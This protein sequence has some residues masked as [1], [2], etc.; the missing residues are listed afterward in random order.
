[1]NDQ[2]SKA[3][4]YID[5]TNQSAGHL[6]TGLPSGGVRLVFLTLIAI[7]FC[8][9][10]A[11]NADAALILNRPNYL[12][13][14]NGLVGYWSFNQ[15]DMA[16]S[17]NDTYA[18]D[19]SGNGNRGQLVNMSTSSARVAGKLG[20]A[21]S[22]DGVNDY[23][24]IA[25]TN[26]SLRF[27]GNATV[28][29]WVKLNS[30]PNEQTAIFRNQAD[31][32]FSEWGISFDVVSYGSPAEPVLYVVHTEGGAHQHNSGDTT[33]KIALGRWYHLVGVWDSPNLLV[34]MN[35]VLET[36]ANVGIGTL[37][38]G[39]NAASKIGTRTPGD[40]V[41]DGL[42]DDVRVYSRALSAD[43]IKRLY[44]IGG[45]L[46]VNTQINNDF[47]KNGLVGWWTFDGKDMA[48]GGASVTAYDRSGNNNTGTLT[49]GPTRVIG[50]LGQAL[51]FD[52][53]DDFVDVDT[54]SNDSLDI[55]SAQS[56]TL[57][58][59][60]KTQSAVS[61]PV[62][63]QRLDGTP[64][65]RLYL[66]ASGKASFALRGAVGGETEISSLGRKDDGTWHHVVGI[67]DTA[68]DVMKL[69][70]DGILEANSPDGTVGDLATVTNLVIGTHQATQ[71]FDGSIDDVRVYNRALTPDEI[72]RLYRI[73]GTL[74]VNTQI[75]NDSLAKGLVG[76]W[77]FNAPDMAAGINNVW[78][79]DRSG[80]VNNGR[81]A[82][83]S[84]ST[85][86][87]PGK[88]GQALNFDGVN[89]F[90]DV[91]V[92]SAS[93]Q[94]SLPI[95]VSAWVNTSNT[96]LDC[97]LVFTNNGTSN[98]YGGVAMELCVG[99]TADVDF[100]DGGIPDA[101]NRRTK[102]STA[103]IAANTWYHIVGVIRGATDMSIYINGVDA[104]GAYSGTGGAMAYSTTASDIGSNDWAQSYFVGKID[105]VRV[106]NR[107]LTADEIKRLYTL[108]R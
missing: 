19:L 65:Y 11:E 5:G 6:V 95:T 93:L 63:M 97:Q 83:T 39:T 33:Q 42:I 100:G 34:Y 68:Q 24:N 18:L 45:T 43:E 102:T 62:I 25:N 14:N 69:Y 23:V 108:G 4:V 70:V 84:T 88:I 104:G 29:A 2:K 20:Q 49:N 7:V 66:L 38:I 13:L 46:H 81:L 10:S 85:V 55:L 105:D 31:D 17:P 94:P 8:F 32:A 48:T 9:F 60:I 59:W 79:L 75:N 52:G 106:Y 37:R 28:S 51:S 54:T 30:Y 36:A 96:S 72:K 101:T 99:G 12:G 91:A 80:N 92:S 71:F 50:K 77:S 58:A 1:M 27:T 86:R 40:E 107:A 53:V 22:F 21:L 41:V 82:N 57:S 16:Q 35:G 44:R 61:S 64:Y 98:E 76:Y 78:A 56:L 90:V 15:Q 47:L 89:D 3:K 73:G 26:P 87:V 74:H 103:T 67:R